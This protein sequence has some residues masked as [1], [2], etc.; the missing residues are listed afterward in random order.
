MSS[1]ADRYYF[2]MKLWADTAV[3]FVGSSNSTD[4]KLIP[5]WC[6]YVVEKFDERFC[7]TNIEEDEE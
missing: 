3:A 1:R 5:V 4:R 2:R 7:A 6:D